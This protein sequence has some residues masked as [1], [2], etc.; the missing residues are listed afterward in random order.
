M[1]RIMILITGVML[2]AALAACT[3]TSDKNKATRPAPTGGIQETIDGAAEKAQH[4]VEDPT[5]TV[6]IYSVKEDKSGLKQN[7]DAIDGEIM[8]AQLLMDKMA[9]L[10][11]VESGIKV[12]KFTQ[13]GDKLELSLSSLE[14]ASDKQI[15]IAIANTFLQNFDSDDEG[16]L[17]L[18][19]GGNKVTEQSLKFNR[20]YKTA[21]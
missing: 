5:T 3:P 10:G 17:V 7:I 18:S 19:V 21:K 1:K 13:N 9:E 20:Q 11:V 8:D 15:Q 12:D 16:E 6:C 2:A 4:V 14:K